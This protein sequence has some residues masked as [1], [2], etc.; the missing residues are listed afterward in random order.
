MLVALLIV[1]AFEEV[2]EGLLL[3][4]EFGPE[5][6]LLEVGKAGFFI[7]GDLGG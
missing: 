2:L 4:L 5:A 6:D 3:E 7:G 1:G